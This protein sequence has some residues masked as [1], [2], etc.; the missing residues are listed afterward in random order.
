MET[1]KTSHIS[2]SSSD[3]GGPSVEHSLLGAA[4]WELWKHSSHKGSESASHLSKRPW[5]PGKSVH[6]PW[7]I[8]TVQAGPRQIQEERY[9]VLRADGWVQEMGAKSPL[10]LALKSPSLSSPK[11][12][13]SHSLLCRFLGK[14]LQ[15]AYP[16]MGRGTRAKVWS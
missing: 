6:H 12:S 10:K 2:T 13:F 7:L 1:L 11:N 9:S 3:E 16:M 15:L 8:L 5:E 14:I 4:A